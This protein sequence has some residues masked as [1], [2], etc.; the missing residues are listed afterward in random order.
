[1]IRRALDATIWTKRG[2]LNDPAF[3]TGNAS[4]FRMIQAAQYAADVLPY[5]TAAH[6]AGATSPTGFPERSPERPN[7][8]RPA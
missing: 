3:C 6:S 1:M 4:A 5:I 8:V 7:P 2:G